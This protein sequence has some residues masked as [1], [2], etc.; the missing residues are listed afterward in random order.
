MGK[1]GAGEREKYYRYRY[2][3]TYGHN[4]RFLHKSSLVAWIRIHFFFF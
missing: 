3:S 4:R 1:G 2:K